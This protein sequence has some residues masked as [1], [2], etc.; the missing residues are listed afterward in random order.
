MYYLGRGEIMKSYARILIFISVM[1]L[2]CGI[3]LPSAN[4]E[5]FDVG[6]KVSESDLDLRDRKLVYFDS[7][8]TVYTEPDYIDHI[9]SIFDG[10]E[11]TGLNHFF[12]SGHEVMWI[13]L[14]FPLN[15]NVSTIEIKPTFGGGVSNYSL[16][17]NSNGIWSPW[18][19][20]KNDTQMTFQINCELSGIWL[21]LDNGGTNHFYF[22]DVI[23]NYTLNDSIQNQIDSINAMINQLNNEIDQLNSEIENS[24]SEE[25]INNL[26]NQITVLSSTIANLTLE[27]E[28]LESQLE[29]KADKDSIVMDLFFKP[30]FLHLIMFILIIIL[31]LMLRARR[32]SYKETEVSHAQTAVVEQSPPQTQKEEEE[33]KKPERIKGRFCPSCEKYTE[34]TGPFCPHCKRSMD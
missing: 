1:G 11:S 20:Q 17:V 24:S 22:N 28:G 31:I 7:G 25:Q 18:F 33:P 21:E 16:Y 6:T 12:G 14:I 30:P 26:V 34:E 27:I 15:L 13:E 10:D 5:V 4:A 19:A 8:T 32:P 3:I 2:L 9:A 23:I 29:K